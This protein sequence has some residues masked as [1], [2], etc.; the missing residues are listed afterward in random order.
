MFDL[1]AVQELGYHRLMSSTAT[2]ILGYHLGWN[3][4]DNTVSGSCGKDYLHTPTAAL[5]RD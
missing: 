3:D 1:A 4:R 5:Y 2:P